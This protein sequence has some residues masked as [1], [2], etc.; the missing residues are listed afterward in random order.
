MT[1]KE[2]E[3]K[4]QEFADVPVNADDEIETDWWIFEKG[5]DKYYI[6]EYFD[7]NHSEG[8]A[9]LSKNF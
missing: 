2:L 3:L 4:W 9:Y 5:T 1:D 7:E 8:V 6:W